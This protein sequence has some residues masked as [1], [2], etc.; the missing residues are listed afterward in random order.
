MT[1]RSTLLS[2]ILMFALFVIPHLSL[3]NGD[4]VNNGGPVNGTPSNNQ[5]HVLSAVNEQI[6]LD[7]ALGHCNPITVATVNCATKTIELAAV[8]RYLFS[9]QMDPYIATWN[10]G[11]VAHKIT[12]VPPGAW[13]WDPS[14]TGCEQNHWEN[15]YD[16][17]GTFFYGNIDIQGQPLCQNGWVDL[18]V[19]VQNNPLNPNYDFPNYNWNPDNPGGQL[20]PYTIF[21]PGTYSLTVY[22]ELGCPFV[23]VINVP[24]SPPVVPTISGPSFMCPEGDTSTIQ[25]NQQ[26]SSYL[27][28]NGDTTQ[29]TV[30]FEPGLWEVTVTNAF[31]CTGTG[32]IGIQNGEV[33]PFPISM[34]APAIC[35][36]D[37]DTLR[38]VGGFSQYQWSNNV[39]GITN[40]VT[41]PGT[42]TVTVTNSYGCTGTGSVTVGLKP[43]PTISI[44]NTP[45]CPGDTSTLTVSGG[46]FPQY[47]W[48]NGMTG[49]PIKVV[50]PGTYSVTVSGATICAT[51]TSLAIVQNP[52]PTTVIAP[53]NL[54]TCTFPQIVLNGL[55]SSSDSNFILN[56]STVG[57]NFV[58]G[59]NTLTPSV[60]APG[61][62]TLL[63][64]NANTGCTSSASVTVNSNQIN[65][66]AP[67][68]NPAT[69]NCVIP[70]L[71]IGPVPAPNDPLL[72]PSWTTIGGNIVS[73]QNSWNP[74]VNDPGSYILTV[75]NTSNG[76]TSTA[77][78]NINED[79]TDPNALIVPPSQ[80]TCTMNTT[81]LNGTGS[82]T[83]PNFTYQW[84]TAN[85]TIS[86]PTNTINTT[87][88][89]VGDYNL[90]VT[91][92]TN[93][94]TATATTTV[95][96]DLNIPI[97]GFQP[98][99]TLTCVVPSVTIDATAS[100]SGPTFNYTWTGP[101]IIGGQGTL[102]PTVN[103]P[104]TYQL[105]LVNNANQCSATLS[106]VVPQDI[107]PPLANA[108]PMS[109]L[110]CVTPTMVLNGSAS[111]G[112][113]FTYQWSA[114]NGGNIVSG[115]NTLNPTVN[116][117]GTY[118]LLV[119][120]TTNGCTSTS[121]TQVQNDAA[122]P[123][124][125]IANP[126]ILTCVTLQ[127][128][129][130]GSASTQGA[131]YDFTWSGPG[132]LSGGNTPNPTVN[133]PGV[134]TLNIVNT[135]NGCTDTETIT[136]NQDI[137]A[138]NALAGP[139]G[140]INCTFPTGV[141]GSAANP[142]GA[143]FT[144]QWTTPN[145]N[146]VG[147]N[148]GP[149][150]VVD[151]AGTYTLLITN[152]SNGCTDTDVVL[153]N[154][155]FVPPAVDAGPT[156]E[157][158]CIQ[159]TYVMQATGSTGANFSYLWSTTN[160]NIL[161][162]ANTLN[163]TVNDDGT[164]T[165]LITNTTNG[166]T[167]TDQVAI[168]VD[169]AVP[170][171]TIATPPILTCTLTS[172]NLN[173]T[174]TTMSPTITYS[175]TASGGGNITGGNTTLNPAIDAPGTYTLLVTDASNS[176]TKTQTIVVQENIV[177][178]V[179]N[180]GPDN[181][182]T[183]AITNLPLQATIVSSSSPNISYVWSAAAGGT[184]L[185]GGNTSSPTI[186]SAGTY[187]VVVTDAINGC[188]HTDQLVIG[189]N[190][191]PPTALIANPATLTC[192][193]TATQLNAL[194]SSQ[195]ASFTYAWTTQDGN[196]VSGNTGLQPLVDD[197]GTYN[198]LITN[199][200]NGCTQTAA[201]VVPQD[202]VP[203]TA[204]AGNTVGLDCDTQTNALNGTGTSTGANMSYTWSTQDGQIISGANTLQPQ[205]G[206]PGTYVL[207]VLNTTNGCVTTDNVLVTED[208]NPPMFT[209]G[210]P[211]LLTCVLTNTNVVGTGTG[212]GPAPSFTWSTSNGNIVN[213]GTTL[214]ANVDA[215]GTYMLTIV[216]TQN[217]CSDTEQVVVQENIAAPPLTTLPVGP[218]TCSVLQRTLTANTAAQALLQWS[219]LNGNIVSGA[220]TPNPI[221]NQPGLYSV[222]ATLPLNGCTTVSSVP[223]LQELNI[224][225]GLDFTLDPPL[226]DGTLGYLVVT[227]INGG[228]GPFEYS[229]D[230]GTT[231]FPASDIDDLLPGETYDLVIRDVNGCLVDETVPVPV[232]PTPD[233]ALPPSF[234]IVL[235]ENQQLVAQIPNAFPL[236][237][238]DQVIWTPT[239]SL[240]FAGNS[241]QQQLSPTAMPF[242]TTEYKVTILTKEGCKAESR[243]IIRV[244]RDIDIYAP[245][246]IWP[247]D[248]DSDNNAFTL[249]TRPGSVRQIN[250]LQIYDRWGTQLWVN[251]NFL[252]DDPSIG[253]GGDY[254]GSP[255]N[256]G[257]FVWWAEVEL[258]DG[259]VI[260]MK[261]DVTVVR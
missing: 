244:D 177:N 75:T 38:V 188:T 20:T 210:N 42:Y 98:P 220:N 54:I 218:L 55:G 195:G 223:L 126:A 104:G 132:I 161:S 253:W 157:L 94:C 185:N 225:T 129:I 176:C 216:N 229:I 30:I 35:V 162:G 199:T 241:I 88:G 74:N 165:L 95:T 154:D 17:P 114:S 190:T 252:P 245:N 242:V 240:T 41:Q 224:P 7:I 168:T 89:S 72:V 153:V 24:Q 206:D 260:L 9:G 26:W 107:V 1:K 187:T 117:A 81:A 118:T 258:I 166:C 103:A 113:N 4:P 227:Q 155:D 138:P 29:S 79:V 76:C 193:L 82:S 247:E 141:I 25:V 51:N 237:L 121:T 254:K 159:T 222:T 46:N 28:P 158:N 18:N 70:D 221:V 196:I 58:S 57:G 151:Q 186:G 231:F 8:V 167:S 111:T 169:A 172:L 139:D 259:V 87:A 150:A 19:V 50:N 219:T 232:P 77:S 124:A 127:T 134:Y 33:Q 40:I 21:E 197:P 217:G 191:T 200:Q 108:G 15:T 37:R 137:V 53:P 44:T 69:L 32:L 251:R 184:I 250:S 257:V 255:M 228:I 93:G 73:G 43:T 194:A 243:T 92:T 180:A 203:P 146:I 192:A 135:A 170:V 63:I 48:S 112:P 234:E 163:P 27:W 62:Y 80:L 68:G 97:T 101:G 148:S 120:N 13:D 175:W 147:S 202:I 207:T 201:I 59:Q 66:Q 174:G 164:Y 125:L 31:G 246:V 78:V 182:L 128:I 36:G 235:G 145:G 198:L 249:F 65:P 133:Q 3:A 90:L 152:T 131:T 215:P 23:D 173:A 102:Q 96:A 142:G 22:D 233:V 105:L 47:N 171:A 211:Q 143:G 12:V 122:A 179:V 109:T 67:V 86:G 230:G 181:T 84:T 183:C 226:C 6:A 64:T 99:A 236:Q 56:W 34:T 49:N 130:D 140:L 83:G 14:G 115:G 209:I 10:T 116:L 85:G 119:T 60:N 52:P 205:I 256:P 16:Q 61:T 39:N 91:N 239:A 261:G 178:P 11:E 214:S 204:E 149:T 2:L 208:V 100:S 248:P 45:F 71:N 156:F 110:N 213:G 136:V 160:G 106:V 238:I 189:S 5:P 212:F 123:N 144:L